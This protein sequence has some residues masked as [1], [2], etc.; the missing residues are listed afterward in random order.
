MKQPVL[1]DREIDLGSDHWI[2]F[3]TWSPDIA[4][5]PHYAHLSLL[6]RENPIVGA[7]VRHK[8]KTESGEHEGF[9]HFHTPLTDTAPSFKKDP[10]WV[11]QSWDPLTLSPSLRCSCPCADHG[12]IREGKWVRA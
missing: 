10:K 3:T 5:N 8:C 2:R 9:I 6:I 7:I 12:F 1:A 4:I 11:V